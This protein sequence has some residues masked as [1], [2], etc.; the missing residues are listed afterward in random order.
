MSRGQDIKGPLYVFCEEL[1]ALI[2]RWRSKPE[3]DLLSLAEMI[4]AL[5]VAKHDLLSED[6]DE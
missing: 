1:G 3:D 2:E 6:D 4:G 5:E